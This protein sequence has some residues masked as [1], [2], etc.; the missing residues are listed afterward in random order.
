MGRGNNPMSGLNVT[1]KM[2][3]PSRASE[4]SHPIGNFSCPTSLAPHLFSRKCT[5][6]DGQVGVTIIHDQF[7]TA[8]MLGSSVNYNI[9][10]AVLWVRRAPLHVGS[11]MA[12]YPNKT[13]EW[14]ITL[15]WFTIY[16]YVQMNLDHIKTSIQ[17]Q[18]GHMIAIFCHI[19]WHCISSCSGAKKLASMDSVD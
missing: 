15:H 5:C 2:Y 7:R 19:L 8:I 14:S 13:P 9:K 10:Q 4:S 18:R 1:F 12:Y 6:S 3:L 17:K 16:M 11:Y